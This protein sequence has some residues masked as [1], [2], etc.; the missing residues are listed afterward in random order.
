M[1]NVDLCDFLAHL[2]EAIRVAHDSCA[3]ASVSYLESFLESDSTADFY[4]F[5]SINVKI[6]QEIIEVPL[7]G[8]TP[9]GHLDLDKLEV[10]FDTII[11]VDTSHA[12]HVAS[13]A[14]NPRFSMT[15]SRGLLSRGTEM[16]VKASFSLKEPC[17]TAE[18]IRDKLNKLIPLQSHREDLKDGGI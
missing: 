3:D 15:L 9:Q 7:F 10:E 11:G 17:E 18:Q 1:P 12:G 13:S 4:H 16:K 8:L 6:G 14:G 5:K 2:G